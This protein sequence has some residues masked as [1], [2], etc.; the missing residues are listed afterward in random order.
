V[1]PQWSTA[2]LGFQPC[3][4]ESPLD[5]VLWGTA[6]GWPPTTPYCP[7]QSLYLGPILKFGSPEQK[8]QW[9]TP[10]TSGDKIGCFALS[11]PGMALSLRV[12]D[13]GGSQV[14]PGG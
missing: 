2:S 7:F 4:L 3:V 1:S 10:F 9:I 12:T 14:P 6:L 11:E 13:P 8:Q 5:L